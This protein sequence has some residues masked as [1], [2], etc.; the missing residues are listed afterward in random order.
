MFPHMT[1]VPS[2]STFSSLPVQPMV[3]QSPI[4]P[5]LATIAQQYSLPSTR[6]H[7]DAKEEKMEVLLK[8][9]QDL[10]LNMIK[11]KTNQS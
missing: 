9:L 10:H 11:S 4:V 7:V 1:S 8:Q 3:T 6:P 5:V 2:T